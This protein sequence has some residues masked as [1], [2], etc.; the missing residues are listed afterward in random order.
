M[1]KENAKFL[2]PANNIVVETCFAH[3]IER[4]VYH[5]ASSFTACGRTLNDMLS[6]DGC[7]SNAVFDDKGKYALQVWR[8]WLLRH[9]HVPDTDV[10]IPYGDGS[11]QAVR[12]KWL[13]FTSHAAA[14]ARLDLEFDTWWNHECETPGC[15][16][17]PSV[18]VMDGLA[19]MAAKVCMAVWPQGPRGLEVLDQSAEEAQN[20]RQV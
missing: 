17:G 9:V 6:D 8:M 14:A 15:G 20:P 7:S 3:D 1:S 13:E 10:E 16:H 12:K 4:M 18:V 5:N 11:T 2:M 19:N